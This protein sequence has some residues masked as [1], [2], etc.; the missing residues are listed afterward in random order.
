MGIYQISFCRLFLISPQCLQRTSVKFSPTVWLYGAYFMAS[1]MGCS[2]RC[3]SL[4]TGKG[5]LPS[6]RLVHSSLLCSPWFLFF[7]LVRGEHGNFSVFLWACLLLDLFWCCFLYWAVLLW[8]VSPFTRVLLHGRSCSE[9]RQCPW[10][11][12]LMPGL[13][14][15]HT[16]IAF[17]W[18][19]S[20]PSFPF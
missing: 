7:L 12:V 20:F 15:S 9:V 14:A 16:S 19:V 5:S 11:F 10:W 6:V 3:S 8:S 2:V 18:P 1:Y 4:F 17:P 13:A